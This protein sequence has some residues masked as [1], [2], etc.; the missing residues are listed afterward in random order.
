VAEILD[1]HRLTRAVH[2]CMTYFRR[3]ASGTIAQNP[4]LSDP[5]FHEL[6]RD[7]L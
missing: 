4:F 7:S 6:I 1:R 2:L 5:A 3:H